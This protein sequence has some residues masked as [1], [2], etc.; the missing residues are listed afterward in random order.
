MEDTNMDPDDFNFHVD[1]TSPTR[2]GPAALLSIPNVKKFNS[3]LDSDLSTNI[4]LAPLP[5]FDPTGR[6]FSAGEGGGSDA[7]KMATAVAPPP[8]P[9][10]QLAMVKGMMEDKGLNELKPGDTRFVV[11]LRYAE[12]SAR[13]AVCTINTYLLYMKLITGLQ[14]KMGRIFFKIVDRG[15]HS[16][17]IGVA[18]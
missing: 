7:A 12:G 1:P 3:L 2:H 13:D 9:K 15:V 11:S 10:E 4:G 16:L 8:A 14:R 5:T 17:H 6:A 18:G